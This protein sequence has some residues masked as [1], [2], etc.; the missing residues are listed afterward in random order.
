MGIPFRGSSVMKPYTSDE[1]R[2]S[3]NKFAAMLKYLQHDSL[4]L[5]TALRRKDMNKTETCSN[6]KK[7]CFPNA[8]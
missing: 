2:I 1:L 6:L 7:P 4:S 8:F 3:G 5:Q